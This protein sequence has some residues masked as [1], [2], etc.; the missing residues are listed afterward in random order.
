M[1]MEESAQAR[2]DELEKLVSALRHDL[3]GAITPAALIADRLRH[4]SDPAIQRSAA[5]IA[6][7]VERVLLRLNATYD[8]VPARGGTGPVIGAGGRRG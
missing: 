8:L 2:V 3:R 1:P 5:R 4:N 6:E 7:V